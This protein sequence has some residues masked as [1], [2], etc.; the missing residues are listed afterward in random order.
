MC[1]RRES[2]WRTAVSIFENRADEESRKTC[3]NV[4]SDSENSAV[5]LRLGDIRIL[6]SPR[7][8][9]YY[10]GRTVVTSRSCQW[11]ITSEIAPQNS[12]GCGTER[13]SCVRTTCATLRMFWEGQ[14]EARPGMRID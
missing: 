14:E 7:R 9:D 4:S 13:A 2:L 11:Q 6:P 1:G 10:E 8:A 5:C 3:K 12:T